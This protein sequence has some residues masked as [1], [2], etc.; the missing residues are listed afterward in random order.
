MS[1]D[2]NT[3][4]ICKEAIYEEYCGYVVIDNIEDLCVCD[5]CI[6]DKI[7]NGDLTRFD[8]NSKEYETMSKKDK[9][10]IRSYGKIYKRTDLGIEKRLQEISFEIM[11]LLEEKYSLI[12]K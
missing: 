5:D 7:D 2:Y 3:C 12:N 11:R 8:E 1:V 9:E 10:N 6:E 4:E